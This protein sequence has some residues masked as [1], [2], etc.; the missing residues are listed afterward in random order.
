M[1]IVF[2]SDT[3]G[4]HKQVTVPEGDLLIH[5]GDI[6]GRGQKWQ[7][8]EFME[9][10]EKQP[11]RYKVMIAGNHDFLAEKE[12]E[13]FR[14]MVPE[15]VIY[16]EHESVE[17]EGLKIFG[18]PYTPWFYDWAFNVRRGE[19]LAACWSAIPEG[20]DILVTHGPPFGILDEV[21]SGENVG[22][23]ELLKK[24][25]EIKPVIHVFGHIHEGRGEALLHGVHYINASNLNLKYE[26]VHAPIVVEL[27]DLS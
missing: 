11:H 2:L 17:I 6:S 4:K 1:R 18:S 15:N 7:V 10:F 16:L 13:V 20:T 22:C 12:P 9:W 24:V 19:P 21:D 3:H 23:E 26:A 25:Q 14:S 5:A 8:R 27:A